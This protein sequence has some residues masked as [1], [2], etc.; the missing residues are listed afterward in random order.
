MWLRTA[1]TRQ[2]SMESQLSIDVLVFHVNVMINAK[3]A[4][5]SPTSR[6]HCWSPPMFAQTTPIVPPATSQNSSTTSMRTR[7][8]SRCGAK[9]FAQGL[10][11]T[12]PQTASKDTYAPILHMK[13]YQ[14]AT[15]ILISANAISTLKS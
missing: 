1:Q 2:R 15:M 10:Y 14:Y 9:T 5:A 11:A 13:L 3:T 7:T 6:H 4:I 12:G 8:S